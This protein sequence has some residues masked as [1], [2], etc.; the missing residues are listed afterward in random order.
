MKLHV[1]QLVQIIWHFQFGM[2]LS[3]ER[4]AQPRWELTSDKGSSLMSFGLE[5]QGF[6]VLKH[7]ANLSV[8]P[9]P[10][11]TPLHQSVYCSQCIR[12]Q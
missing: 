3:S 11:L 2:H 12:C 7:C 8:V 6:L 5:A 1:L 9:A 4:Q 10:A